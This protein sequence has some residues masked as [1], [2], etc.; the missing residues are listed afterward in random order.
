[1][2]QRRD[3]VASVVGVLACAARA[4]A[5]DAPP[6]AP[7]RPAEPLPPADDDFDVD[8]PPRPR[9]P[10]GDPR[11]ADDFEEPIVPAPLAP[12]SGTGARLPLP[13]GERIHLA[14][15][16]RIGRVESRRVDE[17]TNAFVVV[18]N[19]H[20]WSDRF[21]VKARTI[22]IWLDAEK[23]PDLSTLFGG[24]EEA[25]G[26][27][28]AVPGGSRATP[29]TA[30]PPRRRATS[31]AP[32][33]GSRVQESVISD[34]VVG[35]YAEGGVDLTATLAQGTFAFRAFELYLEPRTQR[36][37]LV[38]PRFD[39]VVEGSEVT[40]LDRETGGSKRVPFPVPIHVRA[41]RARG[42]AA[43]FLAFD[44]AEVTTARA[45]DRALMQVRSITIEQ[46]GEAAASEPLFQG[47]AQPRTLRFD[48]RGIAVRGERL[49]LA[50]VPRVAF[51]GEKGISELPLRIRRV[52]TGS[53][54]SLGRYGFV[55]VGGEE[56][57][58][59]WLDW[60][61]D[62]G[63]YTKRGPAV[64]GD[65]LWK[66]GKQARSDLEKGEP[67][68]DAWRGRLRTFAVYDMTGNDRRDFDAGE[69][70]RGFAE[71]ETRYDPN[72][73]WRFDVEASRF[74]DRGVQ[75]E[76]DESDARNHKD[77]ETYG[78]VRW[79]E[80][81]AAATLTAGV[82]ARDFVTESFGQPEVAL[83]SESVPLPSPRRGPALDLSTEL[84]AGRLVRRFDE[85]LPDDGYEA[86]RIDVT[87]RVHAPFSLGDVRVSPWV[88]G[89]WTAYYDRDD[90]G[91]DVERSAMEAGIRANL[92]VHK[93]FG[94]WGGPW[95]LDGL[96]HVVDVDAG[97][98]ARF[99][100]DSDPEDAPFF[101]RI[102]AE[103]DRTELFLELRNRLETRRGV[104][105]REQNVALLDARLRASFWPGEV[106]PYRRRG[107]GEVEG[108]LEAELLPRTA[109]LTASA[110][111]SFDR[112]NL[113]RASGGVLF[114]PT[115]DLTIGFGVRYL[116]DEI[117]APWI[118]AYF[119]WNE[120]WGARLAAV[121]DV[122]AGG[123]GSLRLSLLRFSEDHQ[124]EAGITL[125]E[126]GSDVGVFFN[127]VP[128]VGGEPLR[129]PFQAHDD[130][131]IVR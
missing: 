31:G 105:R 91:E 126:D 102:D 57:T 6:P 111:A 107:P 59:P 97:A 17:K 121:E 40:R 19:P 8:A 30:S 127:L 92:Q 128:S 27:G 75:R 122:E 56:G 4:R 85:A 66:L 130:I 106:G 37:L 88:G 77:R 76:F 114:A 55:G 29:G 131:G 47:F 87:E 125:R 110:L 52:T 53:R 22:V 34:A 82:H 35:I 1:V 78:R 43:G 24:A 70:T 9:R 58:P 46:F 32:G 93:D 65:V 108:W 72:P 13:Q 100:D 112:A 109:W 95:G 28:D 44:E 80:G 62:V 129:W 23:T 50:Y 118:D 7:V 10:D 67:L 86:W 20:V 68:P 63:G 38:E 71:L 48:A 124:L 41:Q 51:G 42:L 36:A 96:R 21:S 3:A 99:L 84:R 69:G 103:E 73:R 16:R 54:S 79:R 49:P 101:D 90:G 64:G 83:W 119:R 61:V 117:L 113:R 81:G 94:A 116:E 12:F 98:Y 60:T 15:D 14:T 123:G 26:D 2:L 5:Q 11:P 89:R 25:A 39:T 45:N 74:S 33:S 104:G 18:G 115:D 120:K